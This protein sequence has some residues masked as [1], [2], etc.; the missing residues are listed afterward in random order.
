MLDDGITIKEVP[1]AI[2]T[3]E[4]PDYSHPD[5]SLT[6]PVNVMFQSTEFHTSNTLSVQMRLK[7]HQIY[8]KPELTTALHI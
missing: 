6:S 8:S 4:K 5:L 3:E 1:G 7:D 2:I